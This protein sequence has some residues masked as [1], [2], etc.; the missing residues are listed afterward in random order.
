[1]SKHRLLIIYV[2][3]TSHDPQYD[4]LLKTH[5]CETKSNLGLTF[6][7]AYGEV[8]SGPR[9]IYGYTCSLC[10]SSSDVIRPAVTT[11]RIIQEENPKRNLKIWIKKKSKSKNFKLKISKSK[12]F[13]CPSQQASSYRCAAFITK[14][15]QMIGCIIYPQPAMMDELITP[16]P[17][18]GVTSPPYK[19]SHY[20]LNPSIA[21]IIQQDYQ[22]IC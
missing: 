17:P 2:N 12:M 5:H 20:Y 15:Q 22:S 9:A 19:T 16:S 13:K 7:S 14:P 1:M 21:S 11:V 6:Q 3:H 18:N 4:W 10:L 8:I